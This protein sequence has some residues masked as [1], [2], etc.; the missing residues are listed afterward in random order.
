MGFDT[1]NAPILLDYE[2][3]LAHYHSVKPIRKKTVRP[4]GVRRYH[5]T[6]SIDMDGDDV[7]LVYLNSPVVV[8]HPDNSITL[9]CPAYVSAYVPDN[10]IHF[11]P[12]GVRFE[13]NKVRMAIYN[14]DTDERILIKRKE[15]VRLI[16]SGKTKPWHLRERRVW[17]FEKMPSEYNYVKRTGVVPKIARDK[18]GA[19]LQWF[20]DTAQISQTISVD[21]VNDA[22]SRLVYAVTGNTAKDVNNFRDEYQAIKWDAEPMLVDKKRL[23]SWDLEVI[24]LY[25]MGGKNAYKPKGFHFAGVCMLYN[26]MLAGNEEHWYD[27]LCIIA[28]Q[29]IRKRWDKALYNVDGVGNREAIVEYIHKIVSIVHRDEAFKRVELPQG[30]LPSKTNRDIFDDYSFTHIPEKTDIVSETSTQAGE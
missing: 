29:Q 17:A 24:E 8:W 14:Q 18:F 13:W 30:V 3:A 27:A 11:T 19:F 28:M 7:V 23:M 12:P 4:L 26:W 22:T 2:S 10:L 9:R 25:P 20:D 16:P 6:A 5:A 15:S 1:V 21:D